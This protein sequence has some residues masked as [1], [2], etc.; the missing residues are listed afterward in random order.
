M[1]NNKNDKSKWIIGMSHCQ[2]SNCKTKFRFDRT[3]ETYFNFYNFE[4]C[5]KCGKKMNNV[6]AF[7]RW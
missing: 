4:Y 5:P 3:H 2:C 6:Y 1:N 7:K